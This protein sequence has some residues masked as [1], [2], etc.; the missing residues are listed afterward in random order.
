[1]VAHPNQDNVDFDTDVNVNID[2][3]VDVASVAQAAGYKQVCDLEQHLRAD[4]RTVAAQI[5]EHVPAGPP[6]IR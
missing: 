1:M 2:V 4:G 3:D 5:T 6:E